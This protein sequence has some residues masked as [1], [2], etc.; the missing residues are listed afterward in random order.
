MTEALAFWGVAIG[1]GVLALPLALRLFPRFPDAGAGLSFTLGL[2]LVAAGYFLLRVVGLPAGQIGFIVAIILFAV[3]AV[4][5]ALLGRRRFLPTLTRSLPGLAVAGAVFSAL[6]FGY[7][8]FRA[9]APDI[10]HT[11]QPM[12]FLY[13]NAML[14]SPDYPPHDPWFAGEDASYYYGGYLQA[15]VLT[16]ASDVWPA[17]G[18]NLSLAAVFA[19]AGTA[20]FSL[21][22]ALARWLFGRRARRW[23]ALAGAGAVLLLLF[24]GPLA[25]VFELASSHGA[26]NQGVYEAFGVEGLVRCG[27]DA[28]ATCTGRRLDP[29]DTWY[30]DDFWPWWRMSRM[31]YWGFAQGQVTTI[32]EVPAFSFILGDLHPHVMAIPG[33]L[34]ALA[35]CAALWRGRG[36]LSW[37]EHL[38]R[39]W[40]LLVVAFVYGS[41]AFVNA[42]DVVVLSPLLALA[43]FARNRRDQPLGPALLDTASWL[44]PPAV[45][46]VVAFIP[47]WLDFSPESGGIYAYSGEGTRIEHVLLMWGVLIVSALA[48]LRV[49]PR[50]GRSFSSLS[51]GLLL[52]ILPVLIWLPLAAF[53]RTAAPSAVADGLPAALGART[54]GAWITLAF[55]GVSL[56]FLAAA[57]IHLNRRKH[58]ATP[59]IGLAAFGV[60]LLYLTELFLLR[61]ALFGLPRLNTVFKLSYQAWI[62]LSL[63]GGIGAVAAIRAAPP[64]FRPLVVT[65][66]A[67]LLGAALVFVVI[68]VPNRAGGFEESVGLDGLRYVERA[69]PGEYGLVRWLR[70][71]VERDA[72]VVEASGRGWERDAG[73]APVLRE[74][75]SSYNSAASRV[76]YRT[77]LQTPIGWPGHE[78]TWRGS[79]PELRAEIA[80]RQ[81]L[82]DLV[83]TASAPSEALAAL[84]ALGASYVVV[85][86]LERSR[87]PDGLLPP[88]ADFLETVFSQGAV[89]VYRV[90][91]YEDLR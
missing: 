75:A 86:P 20:A 54:A 67:V 4:A 47:W 48:L 12:D 58:A 59:V 9:Y 44:A 49:A 40:P 18:Y 76:G 37:R 35:L 14:A 57:T 26:D 64:S 77:G 61:D 19:A 53:E 1:L 24:G 33:V 5:F 82:V 50:R 46:A 2:T 73:G 42:W 10:A 91:S 39:P 80:R 28:D 15:A 90:P 56:W 16:G 6:F 66:L 30:P 23:V 36:A 83:Y 41:L 29:T 60:L 69:T 11:E 3:A 8:A 79:S 21:G 34:L 74:H 71:N 7:A 55:Y 89:T 87:Y 51:L 65:P 31:A 88:F 70:D 43:V 62:V 17:T 13:L 68:S 25:S 72:I 78:V 52:A 32:T 85:G 84:E 81:D 45:L 63:A 27:P 22:A 38:R